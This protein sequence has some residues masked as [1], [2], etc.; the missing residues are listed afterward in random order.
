MS[1]PPQYG[2]E[3]RSGRAASSTKQVVLEL[4]AKLGLIC[5]RVLTTGW[6]PRQNAASQ[7]QPSNTLHP[8][9]ARWLRRQKSSY[10]ARRESMQHVRVQCHVN[11]RARREKKNSQCGS[12]VP[13]KQTSQRANK[14]TASAGEYL[15]NR[16]CA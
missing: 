5:P 13:C 2:K 12:T 8:A 11:E 15:C 14:N 6:L 1:I 3:G 16:T 7:S 10:C 9:V 4:L